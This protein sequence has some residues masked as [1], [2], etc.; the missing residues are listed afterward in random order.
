MVLALVLKTN[1]S[2]EKVVLYNT[3]DYHNQVGGCVTLLCC[4]RDDLTGY[5]NESG[6]E[7]HFPRNP[8]DTMIHKMGFILCGPVYGNIILC[9][10]DD[11]MDTAVPQDILD[12]LIR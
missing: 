7:H 3:K 8:W 2:C 11:D 9:G 4:R 6:L 10:L 12:A 1:G 5:V